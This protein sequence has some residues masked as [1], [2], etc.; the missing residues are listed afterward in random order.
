[1]QTMKNVWAELGSEYMLARRCIERKGKQ[2]HGSYMTELESHTFWYPSRCHKPVRLE[3]ISN[4]RLASECII[5][6]ANNI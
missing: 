5:T 4:P 3:G 6:D 1:M 2:C